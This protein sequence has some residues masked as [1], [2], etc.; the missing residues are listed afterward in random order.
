[1]LLDYKDLESGIKHKPGIEFRNSS[2]HQAIAI[3]IPDYFYI[4]F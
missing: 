2:E 1:M 3:T 4:S